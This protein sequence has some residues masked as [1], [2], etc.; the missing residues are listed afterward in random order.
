[1]CSFLALRYQDLGQATE[2]KSET[3]FPAWSLCI[4]EFALDLNVQ[5]TAKYAT[6]FAHK[7][8]LSIN[9]E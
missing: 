7:L 8:N 3:I 2:P 5:Q 1:M 4:G 9:Y 6:Y